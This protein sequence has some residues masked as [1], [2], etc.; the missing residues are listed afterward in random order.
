MPV[1]CICWSAV[2]F[3]PD[4]SSVDSVTYSTLWPQHCYGSWGGE[5]GEGSVFVVAAHVFFAINPPLSLLPFLLPSSLSPLSPSFP[6]S[7]LPP[8]L[9]SPPPSH[10]YPTALKM[11]ASGQVDVRPLITHFYELKES[12]KVRV[13]TCKQTLPATPARLMRPGIGQNTSCANE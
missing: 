7:F 8:S 2:F 5:E 12:V 10:S 11:V 3:P 9:P 4:P 13:Y 6:S 1:K